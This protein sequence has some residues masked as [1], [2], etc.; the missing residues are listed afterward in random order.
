MT[1]RAS[2]PDDV[3]VAWLPSSVA[4][5]DAL[6]ATDADAAGHVCP[7]CG[8]SDHG[9]PWA[10]VAGAPVAASASRAG[11]HLVVATRPGAAALGVDVEPA[12]ALVEAAV[13]LHP[14]EADL[15]PLWAWVAK[16]AILKHLGTG[17]RTDPASIRVADFA[18][19]R[20]P[21][22]AGYVAAVCTGRATS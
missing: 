18:V 4:T 16:E 2:L 10:R 20:I 17:L 1:A 15:E 13:V 3:A 6:L 12:D 8:G 5:V 21:A 22:P 14:S 11:A 19:H 9:R 7:R